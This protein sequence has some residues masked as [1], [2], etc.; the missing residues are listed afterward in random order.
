MVKREDEDKMQ[1]GKRDTTKDWRTHK[2]E[3]SESMRVLLGTPRWVLLKRRKRKKL[4]K[5]NGRI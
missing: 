1:K 5:K 4:E 2:K 3:V